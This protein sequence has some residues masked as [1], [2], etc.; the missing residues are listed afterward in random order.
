MEQLGSDY[1]TVTPIYFDL[2]LHQCTMRAVVSP[3]DATLRSQGSISEITTAMDWNLIVG[4]TTSKTIGAAWKIR[5]FPE[6]VGWITNTSSPLTNFSSASR[7]M[8]LKLLSLN[9][10]NFIISCFEGCH[11]STLSN[12]CKIR[13]CKKMCR[14]HSDWLKLTI[15]SSRVQPSFRG[16][17]WAHF[18]NS[19][20]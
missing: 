15:V 6:P 13:A 10:Q 2:I 3:A 4:L 14:R 16:W 12:L 9:V 19:G 17:V 18:P 11:V 8:D 20:W 5:D 1:T 7:Y